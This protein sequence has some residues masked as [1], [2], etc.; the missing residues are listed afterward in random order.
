MFDVE[1]LL[2]R[3]RTVQRAMTRERPEAFTRDEWAYLI[4]FLDERQLRAP[5]DELR[6]SGRIIVPRGP[7]AVWLPNNVSLL[8]PLTLI[9]LSLTGNP[10]RVKAGSRADD[11]ASAFVA[12]ARNIAD[13][14]EGVTV[15]QFDRTDPRNAAMAAE[16]KVRIAFGGDEAACAIDALPH[17]LD[18]VGFYFADRTSEAWIEKPD[19]ETLR[20]LAKVF[21]I[22]GTA[23]CTSPRRVVV[24]DGDARAVRDRLAA[25]WPTTRDVAMHHASQNAMARQ[26]AAA[27]GW[28]AITAPRNAAA[29]AAGDASLPLPQSLFLLPIVSASEEEALATL[30]PNIQTLGHALSPER[31][32]ALLPRLAQTAVTRVVP[33]GAMHHFGHV[34]DGWEFWRAAFKVIEV[35]P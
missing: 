1:E 8:G 26:W 3:W 5:F 29:L 33:L 30:P 6:A 22:Y 20:T 19:D 2:A 25:L 7:I 35:Q 18:S 17:P 16:A 9:L 24:L 32:D 10:I 31:R 4:A 12:Y 11:L 15:E 28:D 23:G 27:L 34:W 21:A 13:V 14:F